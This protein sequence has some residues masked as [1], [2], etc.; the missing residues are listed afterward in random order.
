V[1]KIEQCVC[2][3][4]VLAH[5]GRIDQKRAGKMAVELN[6]L[7][8]R[9]DRKLRDSWRNLYRTE[10]PKKIARS[11]LI[12]GIGY[13]MQE[14]AMGGLKS[15][16]RRL[17]MRAAASVADGREP[18]RRLQPHRKTGNGAGARVGRRNPSG[19]GA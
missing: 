8:L 17:L 14:N 6:G 15:S 12:Q 13:R 10:P 4:E 9:T 5:H 16:T 3:K 7:N 18:R 2:P 11:L 1:P 19:H